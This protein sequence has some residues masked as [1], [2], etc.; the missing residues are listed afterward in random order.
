MHT[1][2]LGVL[3][4]LNG[5]ALKLNWNY[6]HT[7]LLSCPLFAPQI[8][9]LRACIC[10][11]A[12]FPPS[13]IPGPLSLDKLLDATLREVAPVHAS[14]C[15]QILGLINIDLD[16]CMVLYLVPVISRPRISRHQLFL[17]AKAYVVPRIA[18]FW[19][20]QWWSSI[21]IGFSLWIVLGFLSPH[22]ATPQPTSFYYSYG[23]LANLRRSN[24]IYISSW[25]NLGP[26]PVIQLTQGFT[27][28]DK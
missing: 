28:D 27:V 18:A 3:F 2:Q 21:P 19:Q 1:L 13:L 14:W 25:W 20:L 15:L 4:S 22:E 11:L 8:Y 23:T 5:G 6:K 10:S 24:S 12:L 26:C 16:R 7:L 17:P 9:G